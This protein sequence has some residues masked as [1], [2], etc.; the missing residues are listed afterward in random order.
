MIRL[1]VCLV[2]NQ[3]TVESFAALLL[4]A[5]RLYDGPDLKLFILVGWERRPS[6]VSSTDDLLLL[7]ISG[8]VVRQAR[9]L[10]LSCNTLYLLSLRLCFFIVLGRN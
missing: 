5:V 10:H 1:S 4:H 3:I 7:Q 9:D 2:I 6:S 8:V